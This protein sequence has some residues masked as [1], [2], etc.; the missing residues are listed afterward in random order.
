MYKRQAKELLNGERII[1]INA[2]KS[3][4]T[5]RK[6]DIYAKYKQ[7]VNRADRANPRKGPHFPKTPDRLLKRT[8]RGMINY[9]TQRGK[10][11]MKNLRVYI[12]VPEEYKKK[13][14]DHGIRAPSGSFITLR[15]LCLF[16][17]WKGE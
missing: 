6:E 8:I 13:V 2:E 12:G 16:L 7:R 9:R 11:A 10:K 3:I 4:I 15:E 17:G 14:V 5:G 1:I